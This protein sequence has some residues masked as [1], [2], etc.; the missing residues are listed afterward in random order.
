MKRKHFYN[1]EQT[2]RKMQH[3]HDLDVL[4]LLRWLYLIV[5]FGFYLYTRSTTV[6]AENSK[7]LFLYELAVLIAEGLIFSSTALVGLWQ[8][9][10]SVCRRILEQLLPRR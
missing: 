9:R 7:L 3:F 5:A 10:K 2:A 4:G 8:V 1:R 6:D